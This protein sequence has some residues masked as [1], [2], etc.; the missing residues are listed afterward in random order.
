MSSKNF[1]VVKRGPAC[2]SVNRNH[3]P[4]RVQVIEG[5]NSMGK[6]YVFQRRECGTCGQWIGDT[7]ISRD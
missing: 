6:P 7:P 3:S 4:V 5:E 1:E 2:G